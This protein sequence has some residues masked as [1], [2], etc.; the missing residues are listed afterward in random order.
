MSEEENCDHDWVMRDGCCDTCGGHEA[1]MCDK[2]W[3]VIDQYFRGDKERWDE[4][5]GSGKWRDAR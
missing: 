2:C 4:V 5:L 1:L 3:D